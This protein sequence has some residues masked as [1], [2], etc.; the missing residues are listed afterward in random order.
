MQAN[1]STWHV[2]IANNDSHAMPTTAIDLPCM[3]S[4]NTKAKG[5]LN[6]VSTEF[7]AGC[8]QCHRITCGD[9]GNAAQH[10]GIHD[11][12]TVGIRAI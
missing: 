11:L 3:T 9:V 6:H 8:K 7:L 5:L 1:V 10:W 4:L 2:R 12:T